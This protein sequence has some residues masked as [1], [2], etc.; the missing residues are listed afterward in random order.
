KKER[1][2]EQKIQMQ[3]DL[4]AELPPEICLCILSYLEVS[5]LVLG[6]R[7]SLTWNRH[8]NDDRLWRL[9]C[10]RAWEGKLAAP[11]LP[12]H[13]QMPLRVDPSRTMWLRL[14]N[15]LQRSSYSSPSPSAG[16]LGPIS[17]W[18]SAF[19]FEHLDSKRVE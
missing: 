18:K 6:S 17:E 16:R 15:Q 3:R 12:L 4:I 8:C 19:A 1:K 5:E 11:P 2:R 7:V 9:L 10:G 14:A 13:P